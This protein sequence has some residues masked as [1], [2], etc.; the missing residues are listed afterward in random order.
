MPVEM[1][2]AQT[3][4]DY[5]RIMITDDATNYSGGTVTLDRTAKLNV[6]IK[7]VHGSATLTAFRFYYLGLLI[8][9]SG[10]LGINAEL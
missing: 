5:A 4:I 1:R 8:G 3:S 9:S 2:V 6:G 7:Y 10:Y